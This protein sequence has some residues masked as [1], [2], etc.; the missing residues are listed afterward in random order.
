MRGDGEGELDVHAAGI[1]LDRGVDELAALGELNDVLH[2]GVDLLLGHAEDCAVHVDILA[3]G[4]LAVKAGAD[5]QHGGHAPV[6]ANPAARRRGH[7]GDELQERGLARTVVADDTD[8]LALF[9]LEAHAVEREELLALVVVL[10]S[11][12]SGRVLL[13]AALRPQ[14]LQLVPQ[15]RP[16]DLTEDVL[17]RDVFNF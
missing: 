3:P 9:D 4:Q 17:L 15:R 14:P 10:C 13:T 8:A 2:L 16:A 11:D 12:A 5:L 7:A 1:A 6:Q